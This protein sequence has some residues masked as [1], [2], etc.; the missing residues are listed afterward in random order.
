MRLGLASL[1]F[2]YGG[3]A[4]LYRGLTSTMSSG[5]FVALMG[6]SGSGKSTLLDLLGGLLSPKAGTITLGD[7][8][9]RRSELRRL[10]TWV[11][12]SNPM[13]AGR[14]ALDNAVLARLA[15]GDSVVAA[16]TKTMELLSHLGLESKAHLDVARLS[17]GE[18]QR[19]ALVR[20]IL[21]DAPM[22]LA[23][24]PSGQLD[25]AN[26]IHVID[27]LTAAARRN[28][29]VI[30]STHDPLIARSSDSVLE[31]RS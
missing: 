7:A 21:S 31:L 30:V 10:S 16:A 27:A 13:L 9:A 25:E 28:K 4:L 11:V 24:E 20:C 23:D 26:T 17:G 1:D 22:I 2:S 15:A 8:V 18:R 12:Q 3:D 6:P 5:E 19:I 29:L 14:S